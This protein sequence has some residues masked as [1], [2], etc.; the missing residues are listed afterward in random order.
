MKIKPSFI[1]IL[2]ITYLPI[3]MFLEY[4][5]FTRF[6]GGPGAMISPLLFLGACL[7]G[8]VL[9]GMRA[10]RLK[11]AS[12]V[13]G[14]YTIVLATIVI[15]ALMIHPTDGGP[16]PTTIVFYSVK[17]FANYS[18]VTYPMIYLEDEKNEAL[19]V[20]GVFKFWDKLPEWAII[21]HYSE[22]ERTLWKDRRTL[23]FEKRNNAW[24][25]FRGNTDGMKAAI[26]VKEHP[27]NAENEIYTFTIDGHTFCENYFT[28]KSHVGAHFVSDKTKLVDGQ[29]RIEVSDW[30]RMPWKRFYRFY[31]KVLQRYKS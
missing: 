19:K 25:Q 17:A 23:I 16:K 2:A 31:Y 7:A 3:T 29:P 18:Q 6:G 5:L 20:A 30:D 11:T 4:A 8:Y 1:L 22:S 14:L 10:Q 28:D 27:G 9:F 24:K 13:F 12:Q 21:V 15:V 26:S